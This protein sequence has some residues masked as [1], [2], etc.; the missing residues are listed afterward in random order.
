MLL[1]V[2]VAMLLLAVAVLPLMEGALALN[3]RLERLDRQAAGADTSGTEGLEGAGAGW[4]W[5]PEPGTATWA[6]GPALKLDCGASEQPSGLRVGYW[7]DGWFMGETECGQGDEVTLGTAEFW[8]SRPTAE[9]VVRAR[10]LTGGW[11]VPLRLVVPEVGAPGGQPALGSTPA[12]TPAGAV[13]HLPAAESAS[14]SVAEE[15]TAQK[16]M[17]LPGPV[18]L[19][20]THLGP[21]TVGL[22][23]FVQ[24][25]LVEEGRQLDVFF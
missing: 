1:D 4:T 16:A 17:T 20:F 18:G 6:E 22:G 7:V 9:V 23:S 13:I 2:C 15:G 3:A 10:L 5:G 12:S 14:L 21:V 25:W 24:C 8:G 19:T 11:G